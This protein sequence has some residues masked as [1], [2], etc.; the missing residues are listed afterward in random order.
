[1]SDASEADRAKRIVLARIIDGTYP[2]GLRMPSEL[3]LA[4][5]LDCGRSTI[6]EALSELAMMGVVQSRRGSG[7]TVRD[8]RREA[9]PAILPA[10]LLSGA[11]DMDPVVL[12]T[13]LLRIRSLLATEAVRLAALHAPA[14]ALAPARAVLATWSRKRPVAEQA[15][16]E[17]ALFRAIVAASGVWPAMWMANA[18]FAPMGEVQALLAP[19][20]GGPPADYATAMGRLLDLV[21]AGNAKA[22]VAHFTTWIERVDKTLLG[23]L[24]GAASRYALTDR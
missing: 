9:L 3:E 16:D 8:F 20:V 17:I 6:R 24:A 12:A 2:A 15:Y 23:R 13:E 10:Y 21:E 14:G 11:P 7:A 1:M 18:Y 4:K 19:V 22:A 5:E